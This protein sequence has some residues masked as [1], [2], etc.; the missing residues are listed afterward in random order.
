MSDAVVVLCTVGG[1]ADARRIAEALLE[2]RLAACVS[3]VPSVVSSYRWK[4]RLEREPEQLLLIKTRR[5]RFEALREAVL[6]LHPYEVPEL[7]ALPVTAGHGAY[8]AW[9]D[10]SVGPA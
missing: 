4:G 8:L 1:E 10:E 3:V 9:I 5:D 2:Q 6:G 7:I